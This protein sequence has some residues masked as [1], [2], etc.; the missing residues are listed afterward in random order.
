MSKNEWSWPKGKRIAVVFNICLE[1]WSDGKAP[2]ISPMGNPLPPVPGIIDTMAV[3]WAAYGPNRG[4]YRLLESLERHGAKAS[5]LINAVLAE[6]SPEAVKAVAQGG[7]EIMSHSY[8]MDVIPLLLSDDAERENIARCTRLLEQASGQSVKGWLSPRGTSSTRCAAMLAEAGYLHYGDVFDQDL[9][10]VQTYDGRKIVAIPLGT[11]VN[12]MPF[13]KYG[14][15][16]EMMVE[17]FM[18]NIEVAKHSGETTIIDVTTHAHI[19]GHPRGAY[20]HEKIIQAAASNP[21]V[22]IATRR[23]IAEYVLAR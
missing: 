22:W 17:S 9:P 15:K 23:E 19:F 14:N 4:I 8:A 13:M 21:D 12:D 16:P 2:G 10:Y 18:Q 7:H 3:S 11:D 1:A 20:F 6:R 5:V